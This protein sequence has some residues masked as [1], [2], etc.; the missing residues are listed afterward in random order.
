MAEKIAVKV[1]TEHTFEK[2]AELWLK[3]WRGNKSARHA[4]T[5]ENRLK[6]NVYP[7]LGSRPIC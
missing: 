3:H 6:V 5:T 1:A 2:I 4:S 7:V